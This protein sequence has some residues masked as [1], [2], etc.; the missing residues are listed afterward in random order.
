MGYA[1][2]TESPGN[3]TVFAAQN[4]RQDHA[5]GTLPDDDKELRWLIG[6]WPALPPSVRAGIVAMVRVIR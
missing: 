4:H 2:T 6:A 1:D 5:A 3:H